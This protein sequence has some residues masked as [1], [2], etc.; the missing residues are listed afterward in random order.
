[1][2]ES[3]VS[4]SESIKHTQ[5]MATI[6]IDTLKKRHQLLKLASKVEQ[7]K[8]SDS[9]LENQKQ[10]LL[11]DIQQSLVQLVPKQPKQT[12]PAASPASPTSA[13]L[14]TSPTDERWF[15]RVSLSQNSL[16][17]NETKF[18][19]L[20]NAKNSLMQ[21]NS[22]NIF[23]ITGP[24]FDPADGLG[25]SMYLLVSCTKGYQ[26]KDCLSGYYIEGITRETFYSLFKTPLYQFNN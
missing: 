11:K 14:P 12:T 7:I 4:S 26:L 24:H 20:T 25:V 18:K 5:P 9:A 1:M 13:T 16:D 19:Q 22:S 2:I 8:T 17:F 21:L 15:Y 23:T 10:S 6:E 3:P